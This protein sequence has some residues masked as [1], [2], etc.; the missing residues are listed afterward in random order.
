MSVENNGKTPVSFHEIGTEE[1]GQR[2][3]NYL[4]RVLKGVPKSH[5]YRLIR[6]G[7]IRLNKKRVSPE[8]RLNEGDSLR[9]PPLRL[10]KR[11]DES[12]LS[13]GL[14]TLLN[15]C[16]LFEDNHLLVI[17][18]PRGLAVHGGT[19]LNLGL[20]ESLRE[21]RKDL[22]YL[23]LVHRLD[24]D[25]SGCLLLAKKRSVL[26]K[27][28]A[29]FTAREVKKTYW[30]LLSS[31]WIGKKTQWVDAALQKN[32]LKSGERVVVVDSKGKPAKTHFKLLESYPNACLV[33]VSPETGRTHQIRVHSAFLGK[34]IVGDEKYGYVNDGSLEGAGLYLHAREVEFSLDGVKHHYIAKLDPRFE[35]TLKTLRVQGG[36]DLSYEK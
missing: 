9:I 35:N 20:I 3:D 19:A 26:R 24:K 16:T 25:T 18:K 13:Q 1:A 34:S 29:L 17:N 27:I 15:S 11:R 8:V 5:I 36:K 7:S 6:E 14:V 10:A 31:P 22:S 32:T 30:A 33:E 21:M 4:F 2:L 23:E 12:Y 28:Q